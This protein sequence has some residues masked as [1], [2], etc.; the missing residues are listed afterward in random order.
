MRSVATTFALLALVGCSTIPGEMVGRFDASP[1]YL[2]VEADGKIFWSPNSQAE[3]QSRF[4]GIGSAEKRH[5]KVLNVTTVSTSQLWPEITYSDDYSR[6]T[7]SWREVV[8]GA[9]SGRSV[10]FAKG[11]GQ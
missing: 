10:Q 1:D 7:V 3:T 9:A 8:S 4:V 5:P 6:I 2:V 11:G